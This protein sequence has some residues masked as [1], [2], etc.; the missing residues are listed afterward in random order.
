[1]KVIK[2]TN[3][4][5]SPVSVSSTAQVVELFTRVRL[6]VVSPHQNLFETLIETLLPHPV[7]ALALSARGGGVVAVVFASTQKN[8][9]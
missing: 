4:L 8:V 5:N 9:V 7:L 3:Y 2:K 1:M 6:N